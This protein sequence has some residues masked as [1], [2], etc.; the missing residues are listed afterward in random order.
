M[1][2]EGFEGTWGYRL[3]LPLASNQLKNDAHDLIPCMMQES[4]LLIFILLDK[5]F[6]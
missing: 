1:Y 6:R 3:G 2:K 4:A 5:E